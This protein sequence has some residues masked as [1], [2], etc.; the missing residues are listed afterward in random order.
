MLVKKDLYLSGSLSTMSNT[1]SPSTILFGNGNP[2]KLRFNFKQPKM[3][4]HGIYYVPQSYYCQKFWTSHFNVKFSM[5]IWSQ[6]FVRQNT[7]S[8]LDKT[9]VCSSIQWL[10]YG[11][12]MVQ[13]MTC[14]ES[15]ISMVFL[16]LACYH[17]FVWSLYDFN[18]FV[19]HHIWLSMISLFFIWW[20]TREITRSSNFLINI[21]QRITSI[22]KRD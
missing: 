16:W 9:S 13:C 14:I 7:L 22:K 19:G 11:H 10:Y 1:T 17:Y 5:S 21:I 4:V 12:I 2:Q 8:C 18:V 6:T 15:Y 20:W 3:N